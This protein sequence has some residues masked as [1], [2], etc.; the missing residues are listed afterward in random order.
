MSCIVDCRL[1]RSGSVPSGLVRFGWLGF[2][3]VRSGLVL[4][5]YNFF[6]KGSNDFFTFFFVIFF[7]NELNTLKK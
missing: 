6:G 3:S 4:V 1:L 2:V 5:H 7:E